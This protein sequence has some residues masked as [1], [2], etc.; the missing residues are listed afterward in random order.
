M[1]RTLIAVG[2]ILSTVC[3]ASAQRQPTSCSMAVQM[4]KEQVGRSAG[5]RASASDCDRG[6]AQ[7]MKTGVWTGPA[8]G[9]RFP[10]QKQ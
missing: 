6:F 1:N 4:C 3:A 7:C 2:I 8:S 10:V 5:A 9:T